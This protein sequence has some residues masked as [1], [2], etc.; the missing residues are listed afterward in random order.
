MTEKL[1]VRGSGH[2][3]QS[4]ICCFASIV[5]ACE[6]TVA[7][8]ACIRF[9]HDQATQ[10]LV[11]PQPSCDLWAIYGCWKMEYPLYLKSGP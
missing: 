6:L 7:V 8:N 5:G 2:L 4:N 11:K 3:Q 9:A 1:K 10:N